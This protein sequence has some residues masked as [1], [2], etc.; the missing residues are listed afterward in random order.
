L[1]SQRNITQQQADSV[2][3][4]SSVF[5]IDLDDGL[6]A[7]LMKTLPQA[8]TGVIKSITNIKLRIQPDGLYYEVVIS[9]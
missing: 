5:L 1:I 9:T 8:K 4:L 2:N 3:Q 6:Q 7:L